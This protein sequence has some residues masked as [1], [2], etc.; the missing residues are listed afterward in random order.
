MVNNFQKIEKFITPTSEDDFWFCQ[1]LKRKKEHPELGSNS[2]VVKTYFIKSIEDLHFH[3][4]EMI[5][6][7]NFHNAR[8]G[9][10]LNKRSFESIA[11]N[12]LKKVSDQI[13]NKDYKSVR[14]SYASVCG[15]INN[16]KNKKWIVD[17]DHKNKREINNTLRTIESLEPE[18]Q[19]FIEL[20]ETP[21]GFHLITKPFDRNEFCERGYS[22]TD[23]QVNNPTIL[24]CP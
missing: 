7:A 1:I 19:K 17:I 11:F 15:A 23:V 6:L 14:K 20:L 10:N 13:L 9:I 5:C 24:Y 18:G 16:D 3:K 12:T 2:Y 22:G 8:V 4:D 21:N